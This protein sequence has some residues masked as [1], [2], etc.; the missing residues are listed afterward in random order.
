MIRF[1]ETAD[2]DVL[3]VALNPQPT[4]E[5]S[6]GPDLVASMIESE[7]DYF[8]GTNGQYQVQWQSVNPDGTPLDSRGRI[9]R[10]LT[11]EQFFTDPES[12]ATV[13]DIPLADGTTIAALAEPAN[14]IWTRLI[15]ELRPY[16]PLQMAC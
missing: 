5:L 14:K 8:Y 10:T 15:M 6:L 12:P 2:P 1:E 4:T 11:T 9:L 13:T 7:N 16:L 3:Q